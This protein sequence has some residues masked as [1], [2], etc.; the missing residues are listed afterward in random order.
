MGENRSDLIK[1]GKCISELR[2][3]K[4]FTQKVLGELIDVND[5]TISKWEKGDI[6]PDITVLRALSEAL[7]TDTDVILSGDLNIENDDS[8]YLDLKVSGKRYLKEI[9]YLFFGII[10]GLI[11][12]VVF[13]ANSRENYWRFEVDSE[14]Y[15]SGFVASNSSNLDFVVEEIKLCDDKIVD[16]I[17]IKEISFRVLQNNEIIF[18][19]IF[20]TFVNDNYKQLLHDYKIIV[21]TSDVTNNSSY[22]F[23]INVICEN[24][25][26]RTF[27]YKL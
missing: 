26:M 25:F 2:K 14:W 7:S 11:L 20:N 23:L 16:E 18:E 12:F 1:I 9:I 3:R 15:I 4:G 21:D 24:D 6:A 13:H 10:V 5:K 22:V 19:D 27:E 17:P 8:Q